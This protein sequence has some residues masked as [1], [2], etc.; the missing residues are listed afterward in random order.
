M[1]PIYQQAYQGVENLPGFPVTV[2]SRNQLFTMSNTKA[3]G[4]SA[5]NVARVQFFRTAV[6]TAQPSASSTI[7]G[8]DQ[9]GFNTDPATAV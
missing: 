6:K 7:S 4:V 2:P 1:Q 8:Y 9:F 3:F 5:V